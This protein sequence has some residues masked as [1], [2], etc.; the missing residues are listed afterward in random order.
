MEN[1]HCLWENPLFLWPFSIAMLNYQRVKDTSSVCAPKCL[2]H[3]VS[4]LFQHHHT[5]AIVSCGNGCSILISTVSRFLTSFKVLPLCDFHSPST[6]C[7]S[8]L[9]FMDISWYLDIDVMLRPATEAHDRNVWLAILGV[10]VEAHTVGKAMAM[11]AMRT[12]R[13]PEVEVCDELLTIWDGDELCIVYRVYHCPLFVS[14][15][16]PFRAFH[17]QSCEVISSMCRIDFCDMSMRSKPFVKDWR[18]E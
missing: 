1:H 11:R 18:P 15:P 14:F 12:G 17:L 13:A 6:N 10:H 16:F 9:R 2:E 8:L 4:S 7:W 5:C 3:L